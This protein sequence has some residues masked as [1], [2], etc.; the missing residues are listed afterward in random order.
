MSWKYSLIL[1]ASLSIWALSAPQI[2]H[3]LQVQSL[4]LFDLLL[5]LPLRRLH[6]CFVALVVDHSREV[7]QRRRFVVAVVLL[8]AVEAGEPAG[9]A[10]LVEAHAVD[11]L[12]RVDGAL[13][14]GGGLQLAVE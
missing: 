1:P 6:R 11:L 9:K 5:G 12:L 7:P 8:G 4:Y 10:A 13:E 14:A 3:L 2:L